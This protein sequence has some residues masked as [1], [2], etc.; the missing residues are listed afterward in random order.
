MG[1]S[2]Y[3]HLPFCESLCTYC[4]CN[5]RITKN[6]QLEEPY[7]KSILKEWQTYLE[8]FGSRPLIREIH[9]GGGTPTFFDSANLV[10]LIEGILDQSDIHPQYNFGFEGSPNNTTSKHLEDL[11]S[12]GFKRVSLG[13]Q[14]FEPKV[15]QSVNRIN[16]FDQV[17]KVVNQSREI[18]Y[19]SV[20]LDL[21]YGLPFQ[22]E[23]T[24]RN[25]LELTGKLHPDRIALY[26]YAHVPWKSP[27][28]RGYSESD[29]PKDSEKRA[30]YEMSKQ[31][32]TSNGYLEI[33]MDH[34][35]LTTDEI[36][37][38]YHAGTLHRNFMGYTVSQ[39]EVLIG[40]GVSAISDC[41]TAYA[42]NAKVVESYQDRILAD[43]T[44]VFRGHFLSEMD[45]ITR[46]TILQL[47][48]NHQTYL[49]QDL[50]SNL[51]PTSRE[52]LTTMAQEGLVEV[53]ENEIKVTEKGEPFIRNICSIFDAYLQTPM[54]SEKL[55]SKAI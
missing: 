8:H 6:H 53:S 2:L 37:Q 14:D 54:D 5:K 52:Q 3:L 46:D 7:I 41:K 18:G 28:Q 21:I 45:Q 13:V 31:Y 12:L 32:F 4:G 27:S 49:P 42:Q 22:T 23:K 35:A 16:S 44:A 9:L 55:F 26:S 33:G 30:L 43:G 34:F 40:L 24:M 19:E 47:I 39:T 48:C 51:S 17:S 15:Q 11:F 1:I 25:T 38:A 10:R 20:N 29:L 50:L 36:A